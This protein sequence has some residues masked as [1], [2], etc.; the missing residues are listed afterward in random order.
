MC[1]DR[2]CSYYTR[3]SSL[4]PGGTHIQLS[5]DSEH[6]PFLF[7]WLVF[8][9]SISRVVAA[10]VSTRNFDVRKRKVGAAATS[11]ENVVIVCIALHG[12]SDILKHNVG[13]VDTVGG[14]AGWATVEVI[15]LHV[16][17]VVAN[18]GHGDVAV[19]DVGDAA[20]GARV[21]LDAHAV[22]RVDEDGI[23]KEDAVDG[24]V[25]LAA[26]GADGE[27]VAARAVHVGDGDLGARGDGD[28]VVLVVDGDVTQ[29]DVVGG[30]NVEAVRVV[31]G[32]EAVADG[33]GGVAYAVVEDQVGEGDV[34]VAG[35]V[36]QVGGPVLDVQV[37]EG[38]VRGVLDDDEVVGFGAAAVG[39]ETVPV[40]GAITIDD[41]VGGA[42]DGDV[43]ARDDDGVEVLVG[44]VAKGGGAGED[45][46]GGGLEAS[47]VQGG[48]SRDGEVVEDDVGARGDGAG[49]V[50]GGGDGAGRAATGATGDTAYT[51]GPGGRRCA[52]SGGGNTSRASW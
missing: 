11:A 24:V 28:A 14:L 6:Y 1:P 25:G 19:G 4:T 22:L 41:G 47:Q 15:L 3:L 29:G 40:G 9:A 20:G 46:G 33:V 16:Q 31:G 13:D 50:G 39:A 2:S 12:S 7:L 36:E 26:D 43:V 51:G 30:A 37:L 18:V 10:L 17:T 44:G 48:G 35:H 49:N 21:C 8:K 27:A 5:K 42:A 45:D 23:L 52:A 34:L 32:G 38:R